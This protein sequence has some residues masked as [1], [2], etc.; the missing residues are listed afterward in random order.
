MTRITQE[1]KTQLGLAPDRPYFDGFDPAAFPVPAYVVDRAALQYNLDILR[2]VAN[3]SGA[4]VMAALKAFC[5]PGLLEQIAAS[6]DGATASGVYEAKLASEY[7]FGQI[8]VYGP[9]HTDD[10]LIL[11]LETAD[12][13]IFNSLGQ[14]QKEQERCLRARD[15]QSTQRS[16]QGRPQLAFGIRINPEHS[17][18]KIRLYDP[19]S[20]KSRMGTTRLVWEKTF[21]EA[22]KNGQSNILDGVTG[23]HFHNLCEQGSE[24]LKRTLAEIEKTWADILARPEITWLNMG[25]GHHVTKPDYNRPL[26]ISLIQAVS[27]RWSVDVI[28]EPGEAVAIHSGILTS[29]ILDMHENGCPIAILD[30]SAT[31]HMPDT[32][33]VPY[34]PSVWGAEITSDKESL[35]LPTD[36]NIVRLA[37]RTCLSGDVIGEYRFSVMPETGDIIVLDDMA[38]Y[39]TVKTSTFNGIPHPALVVWDSRSGHGQILR[40]F[41]YQD[42]ISR[43]S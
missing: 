43:L 37:G 36:K 9:A 4:R 30:V 14:W 17:E 25:G 29:R 11:L 23:L 8:H 33:E 39:T 13:I 31:C 19:C 40:E 32:I 41:N 24:P 34:T 18:G 27:S 6:L 1:I 15:L 28:I 7:D 26:L 5:I 21:E 38:H 16:M 22:C 20:P 2:D 35:N 3:L 10:E 42:F 12:H